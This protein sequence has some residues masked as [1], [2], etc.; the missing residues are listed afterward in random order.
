MLRTIA[1]KPVVT[2]SIRMTIAEA[3]R[4]MRAKNVGALVVVNAGRPVG[5]LTD[6]DIVMNVVAQGKDPDVARVGDLMR[7]KPAVLRADAGL[8]D[9]AQMFARTGVRR[10]PVVDR[11]GELTGIIAIDDLV[12]LLGNEM[13]HVAA[14]LAAGLRRAG[15]RSA[16]A[17]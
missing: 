12:I 5:V 3:A 2:A 7:R 8:L 13:G 17:A 6:R 4:A 10:L 15:P 11:R 16:R 14:A 1:I 9:A